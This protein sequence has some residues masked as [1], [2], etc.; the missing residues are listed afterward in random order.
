M[1]YMTLAV[2][3]YQTHNNWK[4]A[5]DERAVKIKDIEKHAQQIAERRDNLLVQKKEEIS[6]LKAEKS[7]ADTQVDMLTKRNKELE[8]ERTQLVEQ[9]EQNIVTVKLAHDSMV[10]ARAETD[11]LRKDLRTAQEQWATLYSTLVAKTDEAHDLSMKLASYKNVGE[12]LAKDYRD[13]LEVLRIFGKKP[14]P[15]LYSGAAPKGARGIVTEVRPNGWV[16]ISIGE[17]SGI[18]KGHRL[19][20][21]RD[22]DGRKSLIGK[23]EVVRAEADRAAAR[24]I[25]EYRRGTVQQDDV[26]ENIQIGE[27]TAK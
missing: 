2:V 8:D 11:G 12:K 18:V 10:A 19:D 1:A 3:I 24:V 21:M 16:E 6:K 22:I 17:D 9:K 4:K 14:E 5:A 23:I 26:V 13:A 27:L 25:P 7:T 20:V 15:E